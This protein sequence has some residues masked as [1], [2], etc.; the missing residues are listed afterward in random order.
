MVTFARDSGW[1][2]P[3]LVDDDQSVAESYGAMC[4]PDA[5]VFDGEHRLVYRGQLDSSR[6]SNGTPVTFEDIDRAIAAAL[7][8]EAVPSLSGPASA[9][10]SSGSPATGRGSPGQR[11]CGSVRR[12]GYTV[13]PRASIATNCATRRAR[14]SAPGRIDRYRIA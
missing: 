3:Y 14:V 6:P 13:S 12:C 9:A 8:G 1:T 11:H 10:R 7:A 2:F 4:T 5:F